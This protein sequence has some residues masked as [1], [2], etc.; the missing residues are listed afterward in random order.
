M[1]IRKPAPDM[2]TITTGNP[3]LRMGDDL[4]YMSCVYDMVLGEIM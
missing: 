1:P 3:D 4:A 2:R